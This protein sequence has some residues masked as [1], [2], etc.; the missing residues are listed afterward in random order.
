MTALSR[1]ELK[2]TA[3]DPRSAPQEQR[4]AVG[5]LLRD[6]FVFAYPGDPP[7]LPEKEAISLAQLNPD[8]QMDHF[9][10]WDGDRA[11]GW[12]KLGYDLKQ[13]THSAHAR[14]VVHPTSRRQGL[15][16]RLWAALREVAEREG[17][18]VVM[19]GTSSRSPAGEAF[20]EHLGAE[21]ALPNR[22]SQ[23]DLST[24]DA[25]LLARWQTRPDGDP[26]RLHV[27]RTIPDEYLERMADM[28][29]VMNTAP[30]GDLEMEDWTITT[31]MI[32]A[33]DAMLEEAGEVRFLMA[34][35]DTRSG[36]IDSF[37][38]M[39][40]QPERAALLHQGATGVRPMARGLGLGK[41]VKAAMIEHVRRQ[42]PEARFVRTNN[43]TVNEAMLGI[44]EAMGFEPWATF[45][46]W[47]LKL[48]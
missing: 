10:V 31:D 35:E 41:W 7:P 32:R 44:N 19:A 20:A 28:M 27:W 40:W 16:T 36:Q 39:F 18:R 42:C 29:M 3:F 43:A 4:L 25:D 46:E 14:I 17:R 33:W 22:Q 21:A 11:V 26:Y 37:T 1:N 13:N 15:G 34:V 48:S 30:R 8:E 12:A 5:R 6:A 9:V 38:E 2:A 24:V 45:T 47:Q 23:L